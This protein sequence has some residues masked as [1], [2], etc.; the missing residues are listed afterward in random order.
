MVIM[1]KNAATHIQNTAPGPPVTIAAA[2]PAMLP[3][4]T[5]AARAAHNAWNCEMVL[6]SVFLVAVLFFLNTLAMVCFH[7]CPTWVIWNTQVPSVSKIP[8]PISKN[9]PGKPQTAPLTASLTFVTISRNFSMVL[10]PW[11]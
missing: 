8:V 7:Q 5:V 11:E 9:R 1:P 2:T 4:P 10:S 3:V 6:L